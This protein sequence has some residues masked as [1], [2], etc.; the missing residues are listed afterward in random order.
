MFE[1]SP[2]YAVKVQFTD[3]E[4][5]WLLQKD[6]ILINRENYSNDGAYLRFIIYDSFLDEIIDY[7]GF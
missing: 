2:K 1:L 4:Y 7:R 5:G 3:D 6:N